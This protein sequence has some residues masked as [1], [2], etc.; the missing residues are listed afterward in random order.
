MPIVDFQPTGRK[1]EIETDASI[2]DAARKAGVGLPAICGGENACGCCIVY[3]SSDAS[4]SPVSTIEKDKLSSE[5]LDKGYRLAC[6]AK[7]T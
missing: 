4:V 3:L 1:I 5:D 6:Q 2:L 7:I